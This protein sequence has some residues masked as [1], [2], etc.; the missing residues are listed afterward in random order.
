MQAIK[1]KNNYLVFI[2]I[3]IIFI[4]LLLLKVV[5]LETLNGSN[6]ITIHFNLITINAVFAGFLFSSLALLVGVN[7]TKTIVILERTHHMENIYKNLT[8]GLTSS[9]TSI[10][11]SL[12]CIFIIPSI[13]KNNVMSN[14]VSIFIIKTLLPALVLL[15][16]IFTITSFIIATKDVNFIIKSVRRKGSQ[17]APSKESIQET[18]KSIK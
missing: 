12:I 4:G 16:I 17:N 11:I 5:T 6:S 15:L 13:E 3:T 10:M 7:S 8:N 14:G 1:N 18:L 2:I 9:L